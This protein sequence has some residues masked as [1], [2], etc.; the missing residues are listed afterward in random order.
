M[1]KIIISI[2]TLIVLGIIVD[3]SLWLTENVPV[4]NAIYRTISGAPSLK[5]NEKTLFFSRTVQDVSTEFFSR[6][7]DG[8]TLYRAK[9]VPSENICKKRR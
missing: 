1:R 6:T 2:T 7:S 3:F 9:G 8:I 5:M 4:S